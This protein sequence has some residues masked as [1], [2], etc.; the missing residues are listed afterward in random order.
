[1]Q[2][3][4]LTLMKFP[5]LFAFVLLLSN[6]SC[7]LTYK[8]LLGVDVSPEWN[9]DKQIAKQAKAYDIPIEYNL[10]LDTA[11]YR[12]ELKNLYSDTLNYTTITN[13]DSSHYN[14]L[15]KARNDDRQPTQ[16]R[17]FNQDGIE[18]FKMVNCYVDPPIP[19]NWNV[20]GCFDTFP[21]KTSIE[22]LNIHLFQLDFLLSHSAYLHK[23]KFDYTSLPATDYYGVIIWNKFFNRPSR[24]LI[25][26]ARE[27]IEN[28]D[29]AITLIYINNQ[30]QFVWSILDAE[31]KEKMKMELRD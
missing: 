25:K 16:F 18:I 21:P 15:K 12:R 23:Q 6:T 1:M 17:L 2:R 13:L 19:A 27:Y 11:T 5:T 26:T 8:V 28:T 10:V 4:T 20:E 31:E 7:G 30:N 22:S 9:T 29:Q 3:P 14:T 24:K